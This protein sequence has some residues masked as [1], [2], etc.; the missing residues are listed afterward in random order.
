[1]QFTLNY[2]KYSFEPNF[3]QNEQLIIFLKFLFTF[4]PQIFSKLTIQWKTFEA[5]VSNLT[6]FKTDI[7]VKNLPKLTFQL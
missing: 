5:G 1:M 2:L 3:F 4:L 7:F 6:L